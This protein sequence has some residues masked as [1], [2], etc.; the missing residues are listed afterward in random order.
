MTNNDTQKQMAEA[1]ADT[2]VNSKNK[3]LR[4]AGLRAKQTQDTMAG[5][6]SAVADET[7]TPLNDLVGQTA[8]LIGE[9][10]VEKQGADLYG[11]VFKLKGDF[12]TGGVYI[13]L[14]VN[15]LVGISTPTNYQTSTDT[16]SNIAW[17][18]SVSNGEWLS[19]K[20][21]Y[22][23]L[24]NFTGTSG[25]VP[26]ATLNLTMPDTFAGFSSLS[27]LKANEIITGWRDM[28]EQEKAIYFYGLGNM[29]FTDF[30]PANQ[31][32]ATSTNMYALLQYLIL[33][34]IE[35][36]KQPNARFNAGINYTPLLAEGTTDE[37]Y[38]Q[39][40]YAITSATLTGKNPYASLPSWEILENPNSTSLMPYLNVDRKQNLVMYM[41]PFTASAFLTL[42]QTSAIGR[43]TINIETNGNV[44][45]SIGGIPVKITGTLIQPP[46]QSQQGSPVVPTLDTQQ[47]LANGQVVII[48]E[49][50]LTWYKYWDKMYKTDTFINAMVDIIRYQL[51]YVPVVKPWLN[52]IV[53][54]ISSAL[55]SANTLQVSTDNN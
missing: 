15:N 8:I 44:I 2:F 31:Y 6:M 9:Q 36:M 54:D 49:D 30:L 27:P 4:E 29:L 11:N 25:T 20:T 53:L 32:T 5:V 41:N 22:Q 18:K 17:G 26:F 7:G 52:G 23:P 55:G 1:V 50:Y 19:I 3:A 43:S 14:R 47:A 37:T 39:N 24:V 34:V 38:L 42:L 10:W 33:P 16:M 40:L 35:G 48:N 45:T 13:T 46:Q 28:V 12:D 21:I 51:A